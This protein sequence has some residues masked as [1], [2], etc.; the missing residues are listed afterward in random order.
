MSLAFFTA[1]FQNQLLVIFF[2]KE[3]LDLRAVRI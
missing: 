2:F 1:F 3:K